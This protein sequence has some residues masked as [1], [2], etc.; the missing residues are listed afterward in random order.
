MTGYGY[1]M[2][3]KHLS[4]MDKI[5]N[6]KTREKERTHEMLDY[7]HQVPTQYYFYDDI[8]HVVSAGVGLSQYI[9]PPLMTPTFACRLDLF[10]GNKIK[11][12]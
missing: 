6:K 3:M 10:I 4:I 12:G 8:N 7:Y 2:S 5:Q 9:H 1:V 11:I